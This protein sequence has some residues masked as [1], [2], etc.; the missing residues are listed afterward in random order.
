MNGNPSD[1]EYIN[2]IFNELTDNIIVLNKLR[3]ILY[4]NP[5]A[6]RLFE[7]SNVNELIGQP[8]NT[9]FVDLF[10]SE[11]NNIYTAMKKANES[12]LVDVKIERVHLGDN[13]YEILLLKT[14]EQNKLDEINKRKICFFDMMRNVQNGIFCMEKNKEGQF[15]YTMAVG[16]LLEEIGVGC[17]T[18][19]DKTPS[20][21]FPNEI[22]LLKE[23]HYKKAF[24]GFHTTYEVK[25]K[26][27]LL[28]VDV[29]PVKN[30]EEVTGLVGTVTDF[31]ELRTT[32][33]ELL[34]NE[35]RF[36][37]LFKY[38]QDYII[39]LSK[40]GD[41]IN[42]N[43]S[44]LEFLGLTN[45]DIS[46]FSLYDI[47]PSSDQ[48]RVRIHFEQATLG[49]AQN[50][51][52]GYNRE[53]DREV[54]FNIT[55]F[56]IIVDSNIQGVYLVAKDITEQKK[57][58]FRNA[59]LAQHDELTT[60]PNRR[61]MESKLNE[62]LQHAKLQNK[63]L[64]VLYI[65]L[66]RFKSINDTLGHYIGDQLLKQF[67][68]R[69]VQCVGDNHVSRMGGDE[70]MVLI[71][72]TI[73][74]I[75]ATEIADTILKSLTRPFYIEDFELFIT[76]SI[77]ISMFPST[78]NDGI[79][80][81]K[82]ADIAL[83]KAKEFG[84]NMYQLYDVS[85]NNKNYQSLILERDLRKAI[86]NEE[87]IA[88]FQPRVDA[89]SGKVIGAE[90]LI[91]WN[92]P[93]VG[94]ISPGE[95]IPLA[96]ETGLIIPMGKWMKKR[97]CEQ[98]VTWREA[99]L[100]IV[101]ISVNISSQRFL[102]KNFA[103]DIRELLEEYNLEGKYLEIEITENS[104]MKNEETVTKTLRELKEL[105]VKIFID[106]FGTGYSSFNY[107]KTFQIDGVK[108]DRSFIQNISSESENASITTAMIKMAQHLKLDVIAEGV[109]TE[110][111]LNYLL[112]QNCNEMQGFFFGRPCPIDEFECNFLKV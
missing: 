14:I 95:F 57:N 27:K 7:L 101:P 25:I 103:M 81:M 28:Y 107:L 89:S 59:Y 36:Q 40:N 96:E 87:F 39:I 74:K 23:E 32:Q 68:M 112:E 46:S 8:I 33:Q 91:R 67:A 88:Y 64:A 73:G 108:I 54:Y 2:R 22:A 5:Q 44:A 45:E 20:E 52:L 62:S 69:L 53:N 106:D 31:S 79:D 49:Y 60:L 56:P 6:M 50:F 21:V 9:I 29:T 26:N 15:I 92:H 10:D 66:D 34:I 17:N 16:K 42:M 71:P 55:L 99:G 63:N 104:I 84:R 109:E 78:G 110:G 97:V 18:L 102:Q 11:E 93:V 30:G 24:K 98:L 111:E 100:P 3:N 38:S 65:D 58:Q 82:K 105:G 86:L 47:I 77:G 43:P 70:F 94:L 37:T 61:W 51:E 80:L 90:A 48:V 35:E 13:A 41:T 4:I 83:Y 72:D 75:E 19:I 1:I 76:T 12:F 85:M